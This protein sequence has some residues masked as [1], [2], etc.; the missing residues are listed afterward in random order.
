MAA[1][2]GETARLGA[3]E[4]PLDFLAEDHAREREV[5]ALIDRLAAGAAV[6]D[7]ERR[8]L[9]AF[10]NE[11]LPHHLADEDID[12]FPLMRQRCTPDEDIDRVIRQLLAGHGATRS[13][14]PAIADL[15]EAKE[16]GQAAFSWK[17]QVRMTEFARHARQDMIVETAIILPLARAHLTG[18]DLA[19]LKTRMLQRRN[20]GA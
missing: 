5:C 18:H 17:M 12:L 11:Q 1:A 2:G 14:A 6:D 15:I 3:L 13:D 10:L 16:S 19:T 8:M 4:N 9:L 7:G 20:S